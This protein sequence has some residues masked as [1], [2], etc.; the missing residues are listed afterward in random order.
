DSKL[1]SWVPCP[2]VSVA[3]P[4]R[5]PPKP[6]R[7]PIVRKVCSFALLPAAE[8]RFEIFAI[9][10]SD[11]RDGNS[12]RARCLA[13]LGDRATAEAFAIHLRDH[14]DDPAAALGHSLGQERQV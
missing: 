14:R 9:E 2:A 11:V 3:M 6:Y 1:K 10:P 5:G 12:G 8:S 7:H 13:L 4:I